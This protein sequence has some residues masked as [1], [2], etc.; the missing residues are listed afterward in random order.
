MKVGIGMG[1]VSCGVSCAASCGVLCGASCGV[2]CKGLAGSASTILFF[3][4]GAITSLAGAGAAADPETNVKAEVV[5]R[6]GT[7]AAAMVAASFPIAFWITP[8]GC[9]SSTA[10]AEAIVMRGCDAG[11]G[12][13]AGLSATLADAVVP[14]NSAD[15]AS[16]IIAG[17]G[18]SNSPTSRRFDGEVIAAA[19]RLAG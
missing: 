7:D 11:A 17:R 2:S 16:G 18:A 6:G 12:T 14:G 15:I 13:T 5:F 1:A 10:D 19:P 4:G 9:R 3:A 8:A